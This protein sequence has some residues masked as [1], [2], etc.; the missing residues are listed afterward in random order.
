MAVTGTATPDDEEPQR[1]VFY[2]EDIE[3]INKTLGTFLK[4]AKVS[5]VLLADKDGHLLTKEGEAS[6]YDMDTIST[7]ITGC[8]A[9]NKKIAKLVGEEK[10]SVLYQQ[11]ERESIDTFLVGKRTILAVLFNEVEHLGMI[12]IYGN[13][14]AAKMTELFEDIAKRGYKGTD[15]FGNPSPQSE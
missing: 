15:H 13:Q 2:K 1:L 4:N 8:F 5:C 9:A 7:L 3:K 11:G 14:V 10:Y 6:T 12:R